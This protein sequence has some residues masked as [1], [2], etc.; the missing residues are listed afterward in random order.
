MKT[1]LLALGICLALGTIRCGGSSN[2]S[3]DAGSGSGGGGTDGGPGS[4]G[5][6]TDAGAGT[7]GGGTDGGPGSD[8]GSTDAGP[9]TDGG[10]VATECDG[11]SADPNASSIA[12]TPPTE[13][14]GFAGTSDSLGNVALSGSSD[15]TT[16][17][18]WTTYD[19]GGARL[20]ALHAYGPVIPRGSGF[21]GVDRL[22]NSTD[23]PNDYLRLWTFAPDGSGPSQSIG[24]F[25]CAA[26]L[27]R[28]S[29]GGVLLIDQCGSGLRSGSG[30]VWY[31]DA[32][33][34]KW[35][36]SVGG[37]P[38]PS[39]P[40]AAAGDAG[41][42]V[43]ITISS[44]QVSG[45]TAG[46]LLGRWIA[47]DGSLSGDW[48]VLVAGNST[49]PV[50]QSLIGG[51]VAVMQDSKWV[52]VVPPLGAP[53]P[54]P[55]WLVSRPDRDFRFVRGGKAYAFTSRIVLPA[56]IG[57]PSVEVVAPSGLSCGTFDTKGTA[58]TVGA[59]GS[60]IANSDGCTRRV[61]PGLLGGR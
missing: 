23:P 50:L 61:W 45:R 36:I 48:F 58:A 30:V 1:R 18:N 31:D 34:K 13:A 5:G 37:S 4:D 2:A 22:T 52:A 24:G 25:L 41:G 55:D 9:G 7:D 43:L 56:A 42:N 26:T 32:G 10:P 39:P 29:A 6:R 59:D 60:V 12:I 57:G 49:T 11:L 8:G 20:G 21:F 19:R 54:P 44:D 15:M 28:A 53:K 47:P 51:G 3:A 16:S 17:N 35:S 46:D 33:T 27:Q 38:A 40:S 14:C